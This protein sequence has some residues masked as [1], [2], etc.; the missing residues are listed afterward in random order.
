LFICAGL[1]V[2][3]T[4]A[5]AVGGV[6]CT[7]RFANTSWEVIPAGVLWVSICGLVMTDGVWI[8]AFMRNNLDVAALFGGYFQ[9]VF[10]WIALGAFAVL[11]TTGIALWARSNT[12]PAAM[13]Q[14]PEVEQPQVLGG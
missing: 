13:Y 4:I 5:C 6:L 11:A 3:L 8:F 12:E 7:T 10:S 2:G 9:D 1:I 14:I